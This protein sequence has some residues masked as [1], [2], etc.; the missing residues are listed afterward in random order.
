MERVNSRSFACDLE[1][2]FFPDDPRGTLVESAAE[3]ETFLARAS[4]RSEWVI[5]AEHSHAA[6]GN[7]RLQSTHLSAADLRFVNTRLAEDDRLVIEPWLKRTS[8]LSMVFGVPF[9]A[10]TLRIHETVN[11][12]GGAFVG[13][14]FDPEPQTGVWWDVLADTARRIAVRLG[15]EGYFGPVSVDAFHW[16]DGNRMRLRALVDL[17]A[18]C[19][20]SDGAYRLWR[21]LVPERT[22]FYRFFNRRKLIALPKELGQVVDAL[23]RRR[24]DPSLGRGILLASP[25][26]L[27]LDGE[28]RTP[29]K[30]A[31]IF[32]AEMRSEIFALERWFRD[33]FEV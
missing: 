15:D 32:I 26:R 3:L 13:A 19:A 27:G 9:D 18:R 7:R 25:L 20:M 28:T 4:A 8:D 24:Y 12:D 5:K 22:L 6:L 11:T 31:V 16:H 30:L 2:E 23:G 14:I 29:G 17:N 33:Q 1:A 10:A 21:R